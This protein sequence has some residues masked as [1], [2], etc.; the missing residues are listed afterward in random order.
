MPYRWVEHTSELELSIEATS[1]EGVFSESLVALGELFDAPDG[2]EIVHQLSVSAT[3]LPALLVEWLNELVYVAESEGVAPERVIRMEL[4]NKHLDAT[5]SG[6]RTLPRAL[7]KAV[8]YH[9]LEFDR[10]GEGWRARVVM[11][12]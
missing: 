1:R 9:R 10:A 8:T 4:G 12:V 11:D 7:V 6:R 2:T 3:D 5:I